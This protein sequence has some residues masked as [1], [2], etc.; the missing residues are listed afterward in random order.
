MHRPIAAGHNLYFR[1]YPQTIPSYYYNYDFVSAED[2]YSEIKEEM[3]SYFNTG[4]LDDTMFPIYTD[5]ALKKLGRSGYKIDEMVLPL[6]NGMADLPPDFK[7]VR[8]IWMCAN[9][10]Y[11]VNDPSY[12]Y[13]QEKCIISPYG[14]YD[15]CNPCDT[16]PD[17]CNQTHMIYYKSTG[18]AYISF[19]IGALMKPGNLSTRAECATDCKNFGIDSIYVFDIRDN[20]VITN[21]SDGMLYLVY[22]KQEID[23][24]DR[25]MVPDNF[26][27]QEYIKSFIKWKLYEQLYN[28]VTD[29]TFNQIERKYQLYKQEYNDNFIIADAEVKK[30]TVYQ[31]NLSIK[32]A[33]R[34]LN[35]YYI[36]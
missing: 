14:D 15:R 29:E 26:F 21:L 5:K 31:K 27:I 35:K 34:R 19:S 33:K 28:D 24:Q 4:I 13:T 17:D 25:Q 32:R 1:Q 11:M 2:L 22:Y 8:E 23:E 36:P 18:K 6:K 16:C 9:I 3:R 12:V 10:T 30:Q 7:Y 20:K